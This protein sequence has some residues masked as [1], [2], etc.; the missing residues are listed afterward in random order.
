MDL[1]L[2]LFFCNLQLVPEDMNFLSEVIGLT[3][4][5]FL[6]DGF[7]FQ[8][9]TVLESEEVF[10]LLVNLQLFVELCYVLVLL[11]DCLVGHH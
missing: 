1:I 6:I 9:V 10:P 2:R 5:V 8:L 3:P 11:F 4:Y 7:H